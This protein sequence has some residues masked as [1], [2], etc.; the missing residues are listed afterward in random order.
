MARTCYQHRLTPP[1][2]RPGA[3]LG[4]PNLVAG[5][6]AACGLG[7]HPRTA[8]PKTQ[9]LLHLWIFLL[10]LPC[11]PPYLPRVHTPL[12][13]G[14]PSPCSC[15]QVSRPVRKQAPVQPR[16]TRPLH[17][18][19]QLQPSLRFQPPSTIMLSPRSFTPLDL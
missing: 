14:C 16:G 5:L 12:H 4:S 19:H 7:F 10:G 13:R 11:L 18:P 2:T 6:S 15:S 9:H 17:L 8:S 3:V 1:S